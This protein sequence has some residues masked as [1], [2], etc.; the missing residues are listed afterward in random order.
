MMKFLKWFFL[1]AP[2]HIMLLLT[3]YT[4]T[5]FWEP[6]DDRLIARSAIALIFTVL[7][8]GKYRYWKKIQRYL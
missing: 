2:F 5:L 8:V 3:M 6:A 1:E 7:V 4:M